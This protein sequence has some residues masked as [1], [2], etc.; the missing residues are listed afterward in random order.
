MQA[1]GIVARP[2]VADV[3]LLFPLTRLAR[4]SNVIVHK[5]IECQKN[6]ESVQNAVACGGGEGEIRQGK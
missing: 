2:A 5:K 6:I 3:S 4:I 1:R